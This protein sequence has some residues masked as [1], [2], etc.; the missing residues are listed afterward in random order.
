MTLLTLC[1]ALWGLAATAHAQQP[2]MG[3]V[4]GIPLYD[5]ENFRQANNATGVDD[6]RQLV[7]SND[8]TLLHVSSVAGPPF[9]TAIASVSITRRGPESG[10]RAWRVY[11]P[12]R[13]DGTISPIYQQINAADHFS[14]PRIIAFGDTAVMQM[15]VRQNDTGNPDLERTR[16]M[17]IPANSV[18]LLEM[19]NPGT[20]FTIVHLQR[21]ALG[22][23]EMWVQLVAI[24][25]EASS[26]LK[27]PSDTL[28]REIQALNTNVSIGVA[29]NGDRL[30]SVR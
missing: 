17:L 16:F 28:A 5:L 20:R 13:Q 27:I 18:P 3:T 22:A 10:L 23:R 29:T 24:D 7:P 4:L 6:F 21:T 9:N 1:G 15:D 8:V 26:D 19:E 12:L 14:N 25:R 30:A 2:R 11:F